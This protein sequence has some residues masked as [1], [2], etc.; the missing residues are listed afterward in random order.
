[1]NKS[2]QFFAVTIFLFSGHVLAQGKDTT[3]KEN[4]TKDEMTSAQYESARKSCGTSAEGSIREGFIS[5]ITT[6]DVPCPKGVQTC[7]AGQWVGPVL[8]DT[9]TNNTKNCGA[10]VHGGTVQ[11]YHQANPPKGISCAP[12]F[13]T[14]L[15]GDWIGPEVSTTCTEAP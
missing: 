13:K 6:G 12:A 15:N 8:Y 4:K 1:M 10:T 9:C 11:G 2:T 3:R 7:L 5:D 14:C